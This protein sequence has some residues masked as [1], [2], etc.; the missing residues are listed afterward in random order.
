MLDNFSRNRMIL[1]IFLFHLHFTSG[2][3]I[4]TQ[5][6]ININRAFECEIILDRLSKAVKFV[7]CPLLNNEFY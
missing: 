5:V 7:Y 4:F 2:T 1:L 6:V 3:E